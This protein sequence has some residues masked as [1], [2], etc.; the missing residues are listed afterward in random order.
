MCG[1]CKGCCSMETRVSAMKSDDSRRNLIILNGA[2]LSHQMH[3]IFCMSSLRFFFASKWL[4]KRATAKR[5][6]TA[7]TA[8]VF[9]LSPFYSFAI[10]VLYNTAPCF[11][12]R[13]VE[14]R[15]VRIRHR[16]KEESLLTFRQNAGYSNCEDIKAKAQQVIQSLRLNLKSAAA[17]E[18]SKKSRESRAF[19]FREPADDWV[20]SSKQQD[21]KT[22]I[23]GF[24]WWLNSVDDLTIEC[25]LARVWNYL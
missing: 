5:D 23:C 14:R 17:R 19:N 1:L 6:E 2:T 24:S 20:E 12:D 7:I 3:I 22:F 9:F 13:T 4:D 10:S 25:A 15:K 18:V 11:L 8:H 21:L 16:A